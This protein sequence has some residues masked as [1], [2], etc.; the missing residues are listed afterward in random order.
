LARTGA[1]RRL[2]AFVEIFRRGANAPDGTG[3]R[4]PVT[5]NLI[6]DE[7]T[8]TETLV[9]HRL[10]PASALDEVVDLGLAQRRCET[11]TGTAVHPD[12]IL[13]AR[14]HARIRR[15]V[16]DSVG[17][18]V[19]TN[20]GRRRRL[21]TGAAREAAQ[22][23]ARRCSRRGCTVPA[24]LYDIDHIHEHAKGGATETINGDPECNGHNRQKNR[25]YT[26]I[27]NPRTGRVTHYRPNGTPM[28][29]AGQLTTT[30]GHPGHRATDNHQHPLDLSNTGTDPPSSTDPDPP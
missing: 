28:N 12:D 20:M 26:T 13:A 30:P 16:L 2:D 23:S 14:I 3:R 27:R 25:G 7:H 8:Y 4:A 9:A 5:V 24:E 6:V 18:G 21:F 29:P 1:Q 11:S 10:A 15:V 22:L 19:V 17:V